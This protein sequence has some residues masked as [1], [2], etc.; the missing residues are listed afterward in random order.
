MAQLLFTISNMG[1]IVN[2]DTLLMIRQTIQQIDSVIAGKNSDN[3]S[4]D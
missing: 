4:S 1:T 2:A 3:V